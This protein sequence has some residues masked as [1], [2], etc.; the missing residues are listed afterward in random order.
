[1]T[2]ESAPASSEAAI[3]S[4]LLEADRPSLSPEAARSILALDFQQIDKARMN[5]LAARASAGTLSE[6][7]QRA[8]FSS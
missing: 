2:P 8:G 4:R 5:A 1:M 3:F 7:L 6:S